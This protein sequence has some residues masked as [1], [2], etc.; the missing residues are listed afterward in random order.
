MNTILSLILLLFI[1]CSQNPK[2]EQLKAM[3]Q[4]YDKLTKKIEWYKSMDRTWEMQEELGQLSIKA[5][6]D[7]LSSELAMLKRQA[8]LIDS[9]AILEGK[10]PNAWKKPPSE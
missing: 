1:S 7:T 9:I 10:D 4:R 3:K 6:L 8:V 5:H 2:A